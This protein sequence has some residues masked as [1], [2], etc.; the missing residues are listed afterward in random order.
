M[1]TYPHQKTTNPAP[2]GQRQR[3][4]MVGRALTDDGI[5]LLT[6]VAAILMLLYAQP[7]TRILRLTVDDVLVEDGEVSI[8]LGDPPSPVPYPF[9]GLLLDHLD[10]RLNLTTATNSGARWMFPGR[11]A[12]Q[13][14][15]PTTLELRLRQV[16]IPGLRGRTAALRQLVLQ[17]P[18]PVVAKSLGYS[19]EQTARLAAE[20]GGTWARY[21]RGDHT[22]L[23]DRGIRDS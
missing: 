20:A 8:R 4:A 16:G 17:A 7:L 2:I 3:L 5:P 12:G 18:A 10:H 19:Q 1:E 9:A 6:R 14:M 13:P 21:A 23:Q 11:R 22:R 15:A